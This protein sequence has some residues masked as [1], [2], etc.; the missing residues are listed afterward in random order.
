M[1][2]PGKWPLY[3]F[4]NVSVCPDI[5]FALLTTLNF[6]WHYLLNTIRSKI[7]N[8]IL[9]PLLQ[10]QGLADNFCF[11][12]LWFHHSR[13]LCGFLLD[14][15]QR[16]SCKT[17]D[18][19]QRR[20]TM[21]HLPLIGLS[22]HWVWRLWI[23]RSPPETRTNRSLQHQGPCQAHAFHFPGACAEICRL[24]GI[25]MNLLRND[26]EHL[27]CSNSVHTSVDCAVILSIPE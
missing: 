23:S 27:R 6:H 18:S 2:F 9:I 22:S 25:E 24:E 11:G 12:N 15:S 8:I 5:Y 17:G 20:C 14:Q 21:W 13:A 16:Y 7:T 10:G 1:V 3:F 26:S 4:L 19:H